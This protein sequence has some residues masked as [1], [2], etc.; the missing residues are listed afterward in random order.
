MA[1]VMSE[2]R[3]YTTEF[4]KINLVFFFAF[5]CFSCFFLLP[6]YIEQLGGSKAVI[7]MTMGACPAAAVLSRLFLGKR[8]DV[9][10]RKKVLLAGTAFMMLASYL[11]YYVDRVGLY[12]VLLR[13]ILGAGYGIVFTA[14][15]TIVADLSPPRRLAEGLGMFGISAMLAQGFGP[16]IGERIM[17]AHGFNVL[18]L[19]AGFFA[20][21]ACIMGLFLRE[22]KSP[23]F[24]VTYRLDY[25]SRV[26]GPLG[27]ILIIT[28]FYAAGRG[29]VLSFFSDFA[30]DRG[31]ANVGMFFVY[32]SASAVAMRLFA[33]RIIDR[34]GRGRM[35][36]PSLLLFAA[37][38]FYLHSISS[39]A[40]VVTGGILC[41]L[42]QAFLYPVLM[43]LALGR[44]GDC[45]R[46]MITGLY[47]AVFD[48]GL[49]FGSF[50]WGGVA[51]FFGYSAM[52][53]A[54]SIASASGILLTRKIR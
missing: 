12:P 49:G 14:A 50:F 38:I 41:G 22:S 4:F 3:L 7:G 26:R 54:A 23:D 28:F 35:L 11:F 53:I 31:V 9:I 1:A 19:W 47:T 48:A 39:P 8:M 5:T 21:A 6:I 24:C 40:S 43:S 36:V 30:Y 10:G 34:V 52:Y 45:D 27:F 33:G 51:N 37:G 15:F 17:N 20:L 32:F 42:G 13:V 46:G 16:W 18:F 44:A 25:A 29:T 2:R